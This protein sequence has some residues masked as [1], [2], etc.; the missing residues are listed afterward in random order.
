MVKI[1]AVQTTLTVESNEQLNR[2]VWRMVLMGDCGAISAPG[3]F[4]NLKLDGLFLRRPISVYDWTEDSVTIVYKVVGKGTEQMAATATGVRLDVLT[5]LGN[6]FTALTEHEHPVLIGGGVGVPPLY[7]LAKDMLKK[8]M[9]PSAILGFNTK[10]DVI[11]ADE[12]RA[13][14]IDVHL[15]TA[16]GEVGVKGF[17]TDV[18]KNLPCDYFY[19]CG[20][21]PMLKAI[22]ATTD[23]A[24]QM[25]FEERMG[26][27]FGACMGCTVQTKNGYKRVCKDGPVL[28]REEVVW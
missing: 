2:D 28:L 17:V 21:I 4:I 6:G 12:F 5:G 26:C 22:A 9:K 20:P 11:L 18:L 16:S 25:S 3:Q 7:G 23:A 15:A 19:A 8:G 1:L 27:G 10:D 13:L 24:G 14:G